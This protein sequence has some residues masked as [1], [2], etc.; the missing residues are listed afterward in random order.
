MRWKE[1][2]TVDGT[3][4]KIVFQQCGKV[5]LTATRIWIKEQELLDI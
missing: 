5:S 4:G 1:V 3:G 2:E